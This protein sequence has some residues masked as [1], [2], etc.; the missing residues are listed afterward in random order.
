MPL[1]AASGGGGLAWNRTDLR[2]KGS[3]FDHIRNNTG[4]S[5]PH[6]TPP[7]KAPR[8]HGPEDGPGGFGGHRLPRPQEPRYGIPDSTNAD[9][10]SMTQLDSL[11]GTDA[12][13][14]LF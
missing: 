14:H 5:S 13:N 12:G 6:T 1:S 9:V 7:V 4:D 10:R 3:G 11:Y 8:P 2:R